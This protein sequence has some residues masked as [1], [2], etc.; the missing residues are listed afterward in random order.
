[1]KIDKDSDEEVTLTG[2]WEK[3]P[4][5]NIPAPDCIQAPKSRDN[6]NGNGVNGFANT[7]NWTIPD[8]VHDN[9]VLRLRYNISTGDYPRDTF[10]DASK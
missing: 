5:H 9:C 1:M 4:K 3:I 7:Y 10:S 8:H 2:K 6:H